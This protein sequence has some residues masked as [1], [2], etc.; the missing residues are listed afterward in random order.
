[1]FGIFVWC[2]H[3]YPRQSFGVPPP[4]GVRLGLNFP[5]RPLWR[6]VLF[7]EGLELERVKG[8]FTASHI[9]HGVLSPA[10][11]AVK[12]QMLCVIYFSK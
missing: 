11:L 8:V 10:A 12:K 7:G 5:V 1:M 9:L 3:H 6:A 4:R 2:Y